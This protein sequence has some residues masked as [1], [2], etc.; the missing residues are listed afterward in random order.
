MHFG[1]PVF[2]DPA[3]QTFN[4]G[5]SDVN[6]HD[7]PDFNARKLFL[8]CA[9][10][11]LLLGVISLSMADAPARYLAING[12]AL[13][14]G[15]VLVA[16]LDR[17]H[18]V[19]ANRSTAIIWMAAV[20]LLATA[21]FGQPVEGASRWLF[22]AGLSVQPS[23]ILVPLAIVCFARASTWFAVAAVA[24]AAMAIA[25][26][27]DR[28]MAGV[29][30]AGLVAT[31]VLRRS[32]TTSAAACAGVASLVATMVQPD[33]LPA[34]PHVDNILATSFEVHPAAGLAVLLGSM[35]LV[36]PAAV[37]WVRDPGERAVYAALGSVWLAAIA[38][39]A[40]GNY[41]TPVVGYGGSAIIGYILALA[42]LRRT[43]SQRRRADVSGQGVGDAEQERGLFRASLAI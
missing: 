39:A 24:I 31:A 40:L 13:L 33:R 4:W 15:Y 14:V 29:L 30:A 27:P 28:G 6:D 43:D 16:I 36:L 7:N 42:A 22:V 34:V 37:A 8:A 12:V 20:S 19:A 3:T 23:L 11:A 21:M 25:L 26:Q 1:S 35:L 32:A 9:A 17:V 5:G 41:P 2:G 10:A 38:A 18:P